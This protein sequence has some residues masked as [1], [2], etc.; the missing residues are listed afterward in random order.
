MGKERI[1]KHHFYQVRQEFLGCNTDPEITDRAYKIAGE[2]G[3]MINPWGEMIYPDLDVDKV[4][5][6]HVVV[7]NA[8]RTGNYK[9]VDDDNLLGLQKYD[10]ICRACPNY[11]GPLSLRCG[12]R[13]FE[14]NGF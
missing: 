10:R 14:T 7:A 8:I 2:L 3:K 11:K 12:V 1:V 13:R 5:T 9:I 4:A 6:A